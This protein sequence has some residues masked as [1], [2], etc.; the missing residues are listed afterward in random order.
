MELDGTYHDLAL[1]FDRVSKSS[2]IINVANFSV[3]ARDRSESNATVSV[4]CVVTTFVLL[5]AAK[6]P[7]QPSVPAGAATR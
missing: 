7:A 6:T 4:A 5:E 2:R 3:K 1:F